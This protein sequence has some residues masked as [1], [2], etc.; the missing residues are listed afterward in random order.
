MTVKARI[1]RWALAVTTIVAAAAVAAGC[2]SGDEGAKVA[3]AAKQ[4]FN[5]N[6]AA[7]I[8]GF[9][10][11]KASYNETFNVLSHIFGGLYR[12]RGEQNELTPNLAESLPEVSKDGLTYTVKLRKGLTWSDGEPLT[13]DDVV[14]GARHSLDP[15]TGGYYASLMLDIVGACEYNSSG[16][17][18]KD[19]KVGDD[20]KACGGLKTDRKPESVGV[21]AIDDT[22]VQYQLERP[23]P[24]F[25]YL[26]SLHVFY[27]LPEH[28]VTKFGDKWTDVGNIVSSGAFKLKSYQPNKSMVL[29]KNPRFYNSD[30]VKLRTIN[31]LMIGDAATANKQFTLGKLDTGLGMFPSAE[32][33]RWK[34]DDRFVATDTTATSYLYLNTTNPAL[35]DPKVRQAI[36]IAIDRK[37][38]V[39]KVTRKGDTP[40]GTVIP[41]AMPHFDTIKAGAQD[42]IGE[43]AD[44]DKARQL[45][46]EGGWVEGTSLNL[47]YPKEA[48]AAQPLSESIQSDL[49]DVG[50]NV[51]L[52]PTTGDVFQ[53]PGIGVS[54][55][56]AKVDFVFVG[57]IA[58]YLDEQNFYQLYTCGN[59]D[60]GLNSSNFCDEEYDKLYER[61]LSTVDEDARVQIY[62]QLEGMLTGPD[63][64]MPSVPLYQPRTVTLVQP[65]VK[66][67]KLQSS[68]LEYFDEIEIA[69]H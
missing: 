21:K 4:V 23:V 59:I 6:L 7:D 63:G 35:K 10:P 48:S 47:Y 14:F 37:K 60:A 5:Y 24:W 42:F 19:E 11:S 68:G 26:L 33:D 15:K 39:E 18:G 65:W 46:K 17:L 25:N 12:V 31:L 45:L 66:N 44:P 40:L 27:P 30:K 43:T 41:N 2:G 16:P 36:S 3:P 29:V 51:K 20:A 55:T 53:T 69:A 32:I 61:A 58:D 1:V 22:T 67:Y 34:A 49:K 38:L 52:V 9:D 8:E 28:V 64:M 57:W 62:K 50:V 13:A 56:S 54:P